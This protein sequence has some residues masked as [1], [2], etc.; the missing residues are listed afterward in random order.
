LDEITRGTDWSSGISITA[1]AIECLVE[2]KVNFMLATH[3]HTLKDIPSIQRM[4]SKDLRICHLSLRLD[5]E[6]N[7]LIYDRKLQEGNGATSYGILVAESLGMPKY[8]I[9][10]ANVVLSF[11]HDDIIVNTKSS[12]YNSEIK[13]TKCIICGSKN[14]LHTHHIKP[15]SLANKEGL[16]GSMHMNSKDNLAV[17]CEK[18]HLN[19]VHHAGVN[20]KPIE[21][22]G[23][24]AIILQ[25]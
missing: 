4:G 13:M 19:D 15:R 6:T 21:S 20:L 12:N 3:I 9:D 24:K 23:G 18:C 16:I 17:L 11:L 2:K 5:P 10:R 25:K 1:T 8:F 22:L 7:L 14:N